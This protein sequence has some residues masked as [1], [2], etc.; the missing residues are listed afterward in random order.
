ME[1]DVL[2]LVGESVLLLVEE[3]KWE[4]ISVAWILV[5]NTE[6]QQYADPR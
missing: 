5:V 3:G 6:T 4:T 2:Y 1:N